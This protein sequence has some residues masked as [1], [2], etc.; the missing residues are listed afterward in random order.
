MC[1]TPAQ[2]SIVISCTKLKTHVVDMITWH[3]Q[4]DVVI[5]IE[6]GIIMICDLL[7]F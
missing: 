5:F 7:T 2:N 3:I 4:N 1:D 6:E